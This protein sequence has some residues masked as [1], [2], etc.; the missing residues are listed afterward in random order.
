M[1]PDP[2]A[3]QDD[4]LAALLEA[5]DDALKA[6]TAPPAH[7]AGGQAALELRL[8][9]GL[10]C[11]RR[12]NLLRP[13]HRST[14]S[15]AVSAVLFGKARS[16]PLLPDIR[17]GSRLGKYLLT[18]RLGQGGM[19]VVYEALDTV[20]Q[21]KV[22]IKLLAGS[23]A[24]HP[25]ALQRFL[26]E[27]RSAASLNHPNVVTVHEVDECAGVTYIVMELIRGGSAEDRLRSKG[28]FGWPEA[29]RMIADACRGLA[30]AHAAGL[31]HRDIKPANIMCSS[32]GI[33][34]LADFGL[35][36]PTDRAADLT[37]S[38][39]IAGTPSYMSPEQ[40]RSHDLD[41]R[42]DLYSLGAAYYALLVGQPPFR[43]ETTMDVMLAHCAKPAPDPRA[44]NGEIPEACAAMVR[45][46]L[47][48]DPNERFA[49]A[50][51]MLVALEAVLT[52]LPLPDLS[53]FSQ[54]ATKLSTPAPSKGHAAGL[55]HS[56]GPRTPAQTWSRSTHPG[57]VVMGLMATLFISLFAFYLGSGD[58]GPSARTRWVLPMDGPVWVVTFSRD[59]QFIAAGNGRNGIRLWDYAGKKPTM[60]ADLWPGE[61]IR[62][63]A[64]S[65]D[66]KL[67]AAAS[68]NGLKFW[69]A[70]NGDLPTLNDVDEGEVRVLA[71]SP[72]GKKIAVAIQSA[73]AVSVKVW[74][75]K[76]QGRPLQPLW[77][78]PGHIPAFSPDGK[79]LATGTDKSVKVWNLDT[80][81]L[82]KDLE[83]PSRVLCLIFAEHEN[84]ALVLS[85]GT[86]TSGHTWDCDGWGEYSWPSPPI[87]CAAAF[88]KISASGL[89]N[90]VMIHQNMG[91]NS[92]YHDHQGEVYSVAFSADGRLLASGSADQT[93]RLW[94]TSPFQK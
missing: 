52:G 61:K 34:K 32:D 70:D 45:R 40:C 65:A 12:L 94:D 85:A 4:E 84:G 69:R 72:V 91:R 77:D 17:A 73:N 44:V 63:L 79:L 36:K 7:A 76:G 74:D 25:Q 86:L 46:A 1:N 22:A 80:G 58:V 31:I 50:A 5:H 55:G 47:A 56:G 37:A 57:L 13:Q 42:S 53:P 51:E 35:V 90:D 15:P 28:P 62:S 83:V 24:A 9:K 18:E 30:A 89:Y 92:S 49:S 2:I 59:D 60:R 11:L 93:V 78:L 38:G 20:L 43:E 48:K 8:E 23:M 6:N 66:S 88:G 82:L 54:A 10:A 39:M 16:V 71:F 64:F 81:A 19:G 3:P 29:T 41:E 67:L 27:A 68:E 14:L 26:L 21:R 87:S 33:V 75:L